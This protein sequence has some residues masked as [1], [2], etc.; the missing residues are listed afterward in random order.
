MKKFSSSEVD[1][2][3]QMCSLKISI[4]IFVDGYLFSLKRWYITDR[5]PS[6]LE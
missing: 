4:L 3:I 6:S 1:R 2:I 5:I